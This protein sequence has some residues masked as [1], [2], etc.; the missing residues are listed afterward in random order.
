MKGPKVP[1]L[2]LADDTAT[3]LEHAPDRARRP[4]EVTSCRTGRFG[5]RAQDQAGDLQGAGLA[6]FLAPL[7]RSAFREPPALDQ[8]DEDV[9][10]A[11]LQ[12]A[13][14]DVVAADVN[15]GAW[16]QPGSS[17]VLRDSISFPLCLGASESSIW[18]HTRAQRCR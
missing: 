14:P 1:P 8:I 18:E 5:P 16:S 3:L 7:G 9:P 12:G 11:P 10:A 13:S 17:D 6:S 15:L 2:R 4:V